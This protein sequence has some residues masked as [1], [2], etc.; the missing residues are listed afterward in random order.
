MKELHLVRNERG[1]GMLL[2]ILVI[3]VL[4]A[5]SAAIISSMATDRRASAFEL[6][7]GKALDYAESGVAEAL[8]RIRTGDVPDN[9]NPKMVAQVFLASSG[10]MP[11]V[12]TDTLAIPTAQPAGAWLPYSTSTPGGDVLTVSYMTNA[13][14]TGIYYYDATKTPTINGKTGTPIYVIRS[15]GRA[16]V[17]RSRVDATVAPLKIQPNIKGA[18]VGADNLK[19][20]GVISA[21]GWDYKA[22]TPAGTGDNIV[23][24][25]AYETGI[26]NAAAVWGAKK[27]EVKDKAKAS[28]S[29]NLLQNQTGMYAGPWDALNMTQTQFYNWVGPPQDNSKGKQKPPVPSGIVYLSDPKDKPGNGK[30]KFK[31]DGGNGDGLLYV[32]GDL[33]IEND[34]TFRGLIYVEGD[35]TIRGSGWILGCLVISDKAKFNVSHKEELTVLKSNDAVANFINEHKTPFVTLNWREN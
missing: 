29:P 27:V 33:E 8:D 25:A 15:T 2:A 18:I 30:T 32:N 10:S 9:R 17:A 3:V 13:A 12:G 21:L 22:E 34:F 23:R 14:R 26:N 19:L 6:S 24:N 11:S 31:F 16:G 28:G 20:T 4:A 35:I 7:R 1:S 5:L